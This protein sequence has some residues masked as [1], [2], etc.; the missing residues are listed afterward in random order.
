MSVPSM[1]AAC[2]AVS[3]AYRTVNVYVAGAAAAVTSTIPAAVPT[4][5]VSDVSTDP[6]SVATPTV[7]GLPAWSVVAPAAAA[8]WLIA[9]L[10]GSGAWVGT[11]P[12]FSWSGPSTGFSGAAWVPVRLFDEDGASG[13]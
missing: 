11:V 1:V 3:S 4:G 7:R 12:P 2:T 6:M 5:A 8:P 9:G 13:T 10:P